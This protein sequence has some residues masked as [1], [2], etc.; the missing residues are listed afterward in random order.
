VGVGLTAAQVDDQITSGR[1]IHSVL[2][3]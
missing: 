1:A 3:A 2:A